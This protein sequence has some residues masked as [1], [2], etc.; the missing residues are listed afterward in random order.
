MSCSHFL[1]LY[2]IGNLIKEN[3]EYISE[4]SKFLDG[5]E[6]NEEKIGRAIDT[7]TSIEKKVEP[8]ISDAEA[9]KRVLNARKV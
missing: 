4:I 2:E 6:K 7:L 1:C 3:T 8:E 9:L 5:S